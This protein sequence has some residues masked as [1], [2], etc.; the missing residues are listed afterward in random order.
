[1]LSEAT[2]VA[3]LVEQRGWNVRRQVGQALAEL[4]DHHRVEAEILQPV[5]GADRVGRKLD[6]VAQD[7]LHARQ[8]GRESLGRR[9]RGRLG[10]HPFGGRRL[11]GRFCGCLW[12]CDALADSEVLLQALAFPGQHQDLGTVAA[13]RLVEGREACRG[14]ERPQARPLFP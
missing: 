2:Q 7:L 10:Q 11:H 9:C 12:R 13:Q 3:E 4:H 14:G 8:N 6:D 1:M 5:V